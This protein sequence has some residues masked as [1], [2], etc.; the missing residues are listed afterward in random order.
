[1]LRLVENVRRKQLAWLQAIYDETRWNQ[2]ELSRKAG[3][4]HATLSRFVNDTTNTKKLDTDTVAKLLAVSPIPHYENSRAQIPQGFTER[5]AEP[6]RLEAVTDSTVVR[7]VQ[8]AKAG[9]NGVDP[10]TLNNRAIENL[11]YLP[12]DIVMV[13][14]NA[15]PEAGDVVCAQV[16]DRM[17][18][19]ET[20]FR[21][22]YPP[23]L[24]GA[25]DQREYLRPIPVDDRVLIRGVVIAAIRPRLSL[26]S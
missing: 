15:R 24:M 8:A 22:Y 13:D 14:L 10:W 12:G 3:V 16:F 6:L 1:M 4:S 11:G 26:A 23:Y 21:V 20:A 17:G 19:A 25:S 18:N 9:Q 2:S 5:E 7:M